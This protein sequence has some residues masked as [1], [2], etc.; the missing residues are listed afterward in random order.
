[1]TGLFLCSASALPFSRCPLL[2]TMITMIG[3]RGDRNGVFTLPK[4]PVNPGAGKAVISTP[5]WH[6]LELPADGCGV[7]VPFRDAKAIAREVI[8]LPHDDTR[9]QAMRKNRPSSALRV[10]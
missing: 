5:Y 8:G 10:T 9:P 7:L 3:S 6:A 4:A 1:M 2:L